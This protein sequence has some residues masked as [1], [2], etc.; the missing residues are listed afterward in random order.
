MYTLVQKDSPISLYKITCIIID[1]KWLVKSM[2][3]ENYKTKNASICNTIFG[4]QTIQKWP[5][6]R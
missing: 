5:T 4:M 3:L 1:R 6:V 2:S